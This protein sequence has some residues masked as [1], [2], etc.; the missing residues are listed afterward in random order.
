[1][2]ST[3]SGPE[4]LTEI[5]YTWINDTFVNTFYKHRT[6]SLVHN[7]LI[8]R[9]L[10]SCASVIR[11]MRTHS[12]VL[13]RNGSENDAAFVNGWL[14]D[15]FTRV[16][17]SCLAEHVLPTDETM[18]GMFIAKIFAD[19]FKQSHVLF[20]SSIIA[21]YKLRSVLGQ[22][23]TKA[24]HLNINMKTHLDEHDPF[25]LNAIEEASVK[26]MHA[27][28]LIGV[29]MKILGNEKDTVIDDSAESDVANQISSRIRREA[30]ILSS[31]AHK[32]AGTSK[33][34]RNTNMSR[35]FTA[36]DIHASNGVHQFNNDEALRKS[37]QTAQRIHEDLNRINELE[38]HSDEPVNTIDTLPPANKQQK[39]LPIRQ[40]RK[41]K[42]NKSK[43]KKHTQH[44]TSKNQQRRIGSH[45]I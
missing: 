5:F 20:E 41:Y 25:V 28:S 29:D 27:K 42:K 8:N 4:L 33:Y 22:M 12:I 3:P 45:S 44:R 13:A 35:A 26:Y 6:E 19:A 21:Y 14:M 43:S 11:Q 32:E 9:N 40:P 23:Q 7:S 16:T 10:R 2:P 15:N 24:R 17:M 38:I 18:W 34:L 1:M 30:S 39:Y 31:Q 37:L 36:G